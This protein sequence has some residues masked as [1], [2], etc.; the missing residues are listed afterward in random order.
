MFVKVLKLALVLK[1]STILLLSRPNHDLIKSKHVTCF[2]F[3]KH[4]A[5]NHICKSIK[6]KTQALQVDRAHPIN[7]STNALVVFIPYGTIH[8][9]LPG[10]I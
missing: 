7:P 5:I 3:I 8:I 2:S 9:F 1:S 6:S 4:V 10:P